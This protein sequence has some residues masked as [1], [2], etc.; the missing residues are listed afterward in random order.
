MSVQAH[1]CEY[2]SEHMSNS[3]DGA[4][5][6]SPEPDT[7]LWDRTTLIQSLTIFETSP[8]CD[9]CN[10]KNKNKNVFYRILVNIT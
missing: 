6:Y 9:S 4:L 2:V 5:L 8:M 7:V 10:M 1:K 3:K